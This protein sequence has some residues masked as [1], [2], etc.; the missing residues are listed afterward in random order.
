MQHLGGW[1]LDLSAW[2]CVSS[3]LELQSLSRRWHSI[4]SD[5]YI[6]LVFIGVGIDRAA[7]TKRLDQ[8]CMTREEL[9]NELQSEEEEEEDEDAEEEDDKK[10]APARAAKSQVASSLAAELT[11]LKPVLDYDPNPNADNSTCALR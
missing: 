7:I 10:P 11:R 9:E 2:D 6:Q 3:G 8:C 4:V 5:R 1:L